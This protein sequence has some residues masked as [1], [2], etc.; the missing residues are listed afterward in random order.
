MT[1]LRMQGC[2]SGDVNKCALRIE[3]CHIHHTI[4]PILEVDRLLL[5][6]SFRDVPVDA[7]FVVIILENI[8]IVQSFSDN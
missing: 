1:C 3:R 8:Q 4:L 6:E 5:P 7:L 2:M